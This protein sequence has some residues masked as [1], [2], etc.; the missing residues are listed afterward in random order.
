MGV[1]AT[2]YKHT[3]KSFVGGTGQGSVAS[4]YIWG[5]IVSRLIQLHDKYRHGATYKSPNTT[6]KDIIIGM[7]SFVDNCNLSNNGEKYETLKDIL[8][9][10]QHD[11]QL[12]NDILRS[13]G[14]ALELS[15]CFMQVIY[16]QFSTSGAP[17]VGGPRDD[18]HVELINRTNNET[19]R[20]QSISS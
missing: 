9:R 15:K 11:A 10:T 20:I 16:F 5:M 19:V 12:W 3:K 1:S 13:S 6:M 8:N 2:G 17:F 18:L 7:L 14:G 4:M